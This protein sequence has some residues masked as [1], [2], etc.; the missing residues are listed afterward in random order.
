MRLSSRASGAYLTRAAT[1]VAILTSPAA[2]VCLHKQLGW[3]VG[4]SLFG[5]DR[6][7]SRAFRGLIDLIFRRFIPWPSLFGT[8]DRGSGRRT[9][10][11]AAA[12]GSGA[13]GTGSSDRRDRRHDRPGSST[14]CATA[15]T[16]RVG[17]GRP[18]ASKTSSAPRCRQSPGAPGRSSSF[19]AHL[20]LP[21]PVRADGLH[22]HQRRSA[23]SSP[24]T[25]TGACASTTCAARRRRRRRCAAS[26][27]SGS[28][29]SS[30][31][32][33][34]ASASVGCSS[35]ARP[36]PARRCSRRRSRPASTRRSSRCPG[37]G[38]A[39]TLHRAWT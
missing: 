20:Q 8:D 16:A 6:A 2:F 38:F 3:G 9:S 10:S 25:P 11:T 19:F 15:S 22:G 28:R 23:A 33:R 26:S 17:W 29:A 35:S 1:G 21:D 36:A 32:K 5:D 13:S 14:R 4:W 12:R 7:R 39:Q 30:S 34:A 18:P 24:A 27:R 31:R 37:S